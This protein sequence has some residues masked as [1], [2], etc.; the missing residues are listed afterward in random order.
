MAAQSLQ[1]RQDFINVDREH[2]LLRLRVKT[3]LEFSARADL[4]G[5]QVTFLAICLCVHTA[6]REE[7]MAMAK[8]GILL[9]IIPAAFFGIVFELRRAS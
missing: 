5:A 9:L 3:M 2:L 6:I 7:L 8:F 4:A 1:V